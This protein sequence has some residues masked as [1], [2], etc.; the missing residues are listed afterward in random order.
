[1]FATKPAQFFIAILGT[2]FRFCM[3][4]QDTNTNKVP[5]ANVDRNQD[6]DLSSS[7]PSSN[8]SSS[9]QSFLSDEQI[10]RLSISRQEFSGPLPPP[11]TLKAYELIESGLA[12]RIVDQAERQAQHRMELEKIVIEGDSKRANWGLGLG[13]C[14]AVIWI[15]CSTFL[16][17][18]GHDVAGAVG[19]TTNA[20]SLVGVF[21]YGSNSRKNERTE[22][23]RML[24]DIQSKVD[25]PKNND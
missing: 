14:V 17:M 19:I 23:Q 8:N 13:A 7:G 24:L 4:N 22:K 25:K 16:I 11:A 1:M 6:S 10:L 2:E 15:G 18:N 20:V 21:I 9:Q 5:P 3:E 12:S